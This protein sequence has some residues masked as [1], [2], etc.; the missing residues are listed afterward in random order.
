MLSMVLPI[1]SYF[2]NQD[3]T[4][5][6]FESTEASSSLEGETRNANAPIAL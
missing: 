1:A 3:M 5:V 6:T 4:Q 2:M